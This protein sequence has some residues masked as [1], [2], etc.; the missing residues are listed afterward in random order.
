MMLALSVGIPHWWNFYPG[1][2]KT[3]I[4][5]FPEA[6]VT[7]PILLAEAISLDIH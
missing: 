1:D 5:R 4:N 3:I 7:T 6:A 2:L